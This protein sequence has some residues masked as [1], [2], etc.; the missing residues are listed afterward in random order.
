MVT[1][2]LVCDSAAR[3]EDRMSMIAPHSYS[4]RGPGPWKPAFMNASISSGWRPLNSDARE[5]MSQSG[6]KD[7]AHAT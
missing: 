4:Y 5:R 2:I 6:E 7:Q 3:A 1:P